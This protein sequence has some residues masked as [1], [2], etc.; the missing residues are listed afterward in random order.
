MIIQLT[1]RVV[2]QINGDLEEIKNFFQGITTNDINLIEKGPIYS[3]FLT[4]NGRFLFDVFFIKYEDSLLIDCNA[5]F[6]D[7]LFEHIKLYKMR[8]KFDM[9]RTK[10]F[11]YSSIEKIDNE[12]ILMQFEDPRSNIM[13][14]RIISNYRISCNSDLNLYHQGRIE[15]LIIDGAH[16]MIHKQSLPINFNMHA[17]NAISLT[18]GCY[19]GQETINRLYRTAIQRKKLVCLKIDDTEEVLSINSFN[20]GLEQNQKI[21][22]GE[23]ECGVICSNFGKYVLALLEI[24]LCSDLSNLLCYNNESAVLKLTTLIL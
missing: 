18:K 4:A 11:V 17:L 1:D 21:F 13:G 19:I 22:N 2:F 10:Y 5:E 23:I 7:K 14:E 6:A 9:Q 20:F 24:D 16:D 3:L 8:N 15:H 12:S